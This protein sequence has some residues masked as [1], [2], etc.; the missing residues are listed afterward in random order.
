MDVAYVIKIDSL[1]ILR[2]ILFGVLHWM[3]AIVLLQDLAR[4]ERVLGGHKAIWAIVI[5]FITFF[6]SLIY[7]LCHPK[8]FFDTDNR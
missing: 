6:G 4:R 5:I 1:Y 8:I 2:V 7:L 3:L